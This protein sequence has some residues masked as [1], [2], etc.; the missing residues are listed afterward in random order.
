MDFKAF[1]RDVPDYPKPGILFKDI[2]TLW[3]D[4]RA[5]KPSIDALADHLK[6]KK[7]DKVLAAESRGF[8]VGAPLA[9][10]LGAGFVPAR[11]P[12]KLPSHAVSKNYSLEYGEASIHIHS[13][14]IQKGENVLIADDLLATGGTC[15]AMIRLVEEL[16]GNVVECVFLVEL[17][18]LKGRDR[19]KQSVF[20]LMTY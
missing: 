19:L 6:G 3:K 12:G 5:F 14:G 7:I 9:Y 11:K 16:G 8:I 2:T 4:P 18:F 10:I 20:S 17:S 1:I 13:D 15:E